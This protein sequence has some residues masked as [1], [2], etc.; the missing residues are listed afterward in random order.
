MLVLVNYYYADLKA[1]CRRLLRIRLIRK[2]R[3]PTRKMITGVIG[4]LQ[5]V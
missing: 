5:W 3:E 4:I 1:T 2:I